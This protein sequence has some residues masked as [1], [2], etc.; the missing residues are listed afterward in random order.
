MD[1]PVVGIDTRELHVLAEVVA[2]FPAKEALVA[3][4][5]WLY[6]HPVA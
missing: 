4:N 5:P 3:W 2:A 6:S 1:R